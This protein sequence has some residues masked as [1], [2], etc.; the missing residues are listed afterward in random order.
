[1]HHCRTVQVMK[2][3]SEDSACLSMLGKKSKISV[4]AGTRCRKFVAAGAEKF[5]A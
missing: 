3:Y 4:A 2:S 5:I 1:M